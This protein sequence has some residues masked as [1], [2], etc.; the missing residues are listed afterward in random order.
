MSHAAS[1]SSRAARQARDASAA[2]QASDANS[3]APLA[4]A[5]ERACA[6]IAPTWPLDRFIAVNPFWCLVGRPLPEVA[7]RLRSLSGAELLMPRAFYRQAYRSGALGD[8][9]LEAALAA[10]GSRQSVDSLRALLE[11][12][13]PAPSRRARLADLADAL[14]AP[15][16]PTSW[17]ELIKQNIS[18]LCAAFF[19]E[20]QATFAVKRDAGLYATWR[21]Y[22]QNDRGPALL[23][24]ARAYRALAGELP[25]AAADVIAMALADLRIPER[26]REDYLWSL[27]LDVNGW[28]S[29]CAYRRWT[30]RLQGS[31]DGA[32]LEL[33]AIRLAWDWM[34][35]RLG[36][37]ALAERWSA[38]IAAW[39]SVDAAAA[40]ER[41]RDWLLQSAMEIAW[42]APILRAFPAGLGARRAEQPAVQAVLCIDVR[43]EVLR[44]ALEATAPEVQTLGFAGFFGMP[45]D[46]LPLGAA[47]ARPQLP[48]LLAPRLRAGDTGLSQE[49]LAQRAR[50][51]E[52]AAAATSFKTDAV[53]CFTF[54]EA[55]GTT[56]AAK[57]LEASLG[58]GQGRGRS[59][60]PDREGLSPT[61]EQRRRPR[62]LGKL[63]GEPC[64]RDERAELAAAM[65]RGMSLTRGFARLVLL[66][67]HGS[68]N[69]NNP[70]AAG[71]DCG[72]CC[73]Q[74]GEVNARAAAALLNDP[75]VREGLA[76]RGLELPSSTRFLAGLHNT[77]TDEV[78]LFEL[79]ELPAT[80]AAEVAALQAWLA[81]AGARARGER[82][83]QLGLSHLA[84][85]ALGR[86][87]D[88]RAQDWSQVR[89]EWGLAN[90]AALIVAPRE[91]C[92]HLN[93]QGRAFLHEYRHEEDPDH[94]VLEQIMTAPLVVAHWI[95]LQYYASTVDNPRYGSGNKALHNV[96]GGHLGVFEGNTGDLRIGLPLQS[97]HDGARWV[98]TPLRLSVFLEAPRP[99]IDAILAKHE[100]VRQLVDNEWLSLFQLD[101][102]EAAVYG[103]RG[104]KWQRHAGPSAPSSPAATAR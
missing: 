36:G 55:L 27:L 76:Q 94:A 49:D 59:A 73:G 43:S 42:R 84:P 61:A 45:I 95:N 31:D 81:E 51:L 18:Q 21:R 60:A 74:T 79:D 87:L 2:P 39:P 25:A 24:G 71:L 26:H 48:G 22:A 90:N 86:A 23:M 46:Y 88:V 44:R 67:G 63:S 37:A 40:A 98:H 14:R 34:L 6:R 103:L 91:H 38:A 20:G 1:S 68:A 93:L 100:S 50:S 99:A 89:P 83:A 56:F 57:L 35:S 77:T 96:V 4:A 11:E 80:H 19:D 29:W 8:E 47:A 13:E 85:P 10:A 7:A 41:A 52:L 64:G 70:H 5:V 82:A 15:P 9:H 72:A 33:L 104:Q 65:L 92:R 28:A 62:L 69:R 78:T 30:A 97:L 17:A 12:D 53:S 58:R 32:L 66:L 75:A 101:E 16:Q 102:G 3:S 54:V